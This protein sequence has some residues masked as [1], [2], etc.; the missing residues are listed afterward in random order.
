MSC[1]SGFLG[2]K[3]LFPLWKG[4]RPLFS[5][6]LG[7]EVIGRENIPEGPCIVASNHR[8]HLDPPVLNAVFPEPLYFLAKEE[9]FRPPLGWLIR[10]LRALPVRKSAGDLSVLEECLRILGSGCKV[11][12]FPEG[13]RVERGSFGRPKPGVGFLAIRSGYPVLPVYVHGT[14]E[15]LPVGSAFPRPKRGVKV[16]IGKP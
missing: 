1:S 11:C 14:D 8:S 5:G 3:V 10:N 12:I 13:R 4:I 7:V 16:V 6:L 9:L 15:I 2:E